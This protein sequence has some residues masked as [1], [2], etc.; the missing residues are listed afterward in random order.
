MRRSKATCS[1]VLLAEVLSGKLSQQHGE[2]DI[3]S[4]GVE[5]C[6][7]RQEARPEAVSKARPEAV[8]HE[9]FQ[10]SASLPDWPAYQ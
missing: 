8:L 4:T 5:G 9:W 7:G 6:L 2:N 1:K 3:K 10:T